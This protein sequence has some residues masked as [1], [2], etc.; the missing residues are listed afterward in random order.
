MKPL[1]AERWARAQQLFHE[2]LALPPADRADHVRG[3]TDEPDVIELVLAMI[4]ADASSA[5]PLD[6]D[7]GA[8]ADGLLAA[9]ESPGRRLGHYVLG[10]VLG[11]GG[12]AVVYRAYR[13][14]LGNTVAIKI[15]RDAWVSPSRRR[16]FLTEQRT[17]AALTHP[18]IA[19]LL[20]ADTLEDG[21]PY[22][23]MEHV[24]GSPITEHCTKLSLPLDDRLRLFRSVC[25][26]VQHAHAHAIVH[27]D[28]K[29]SN[30]LVASDG[31][32]KLLDFGIAKHV[33]ELDTDAPEAATRTGLRPMTP[34]YA[35]PEQIRGDNVGAYTDVYA[36][37]VLLHEILTGA[38]PAASSRATDGTGA[39]LVDDAALRAVAGR[40]AT[41]LTCICRVAMHEEPA[42]RYPTVEALGRDIDRFLRGLPVEARPDSV[43]YRVG[44]FVRRNRGAVAS[45]AA[46]FALLVAGSALHTTRLAAARD[47]AELEAAKAR[48]V[49]DYLVGLFEAAD[50]YEDAAESDVGTLLDRGEARLSGLGA[51]PALQ[52]DLF[53]VLGRVRVARSEFEQAETLLSRALDMQRMYSD[54]LAVA[55]TLVEIGRLHYYTGRYAEAATALA[56]ALAIRSAHL[57]SYDPALAEAL[58]ELGV[59]TSSLGDYAGADTLFG[60]ALAIRRMVHRE[61]HPDLG[62]SLNN[63]AV[64]EFNLGRYDSAARYYEETLTVERALYG[65]DH[66]TVATTLAN[67]GKLHEQ[68][69]N[70]GEAEKLLTQALHIR[71]ARLGADHYETALSLSQLGGLLQ[72]AGDLERA[73]RYLRDALAIR[74]RILG[75]DHP[76]VGTTLNAIGLLLGQRGEHDDAIAA[77]HRV[78]GIYERALG[79]EH[80]FTG[81]ARGNLAEALQARGDL[82]EAE[83][84]YRYSIAILSAVHPPDH[85]ELAWNVGRLGMLLAARNRD[86]EADS[87]LRT[88][89]AALST[90]YGPEHRRTL[91]L[92]ATIERVS[93]RLAQQ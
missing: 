16:R 89:H 82:D 64:N 38:R 13:D 34:A 75:P 4:E 56:E 92:G 55:A 72:Q 79:A 71:Q 24:E 17:L 65:A 49:A 58:D 18:N 88:A 84:Q 63:V 15:L 77:F 29:P 6:S 51:Q 83:R 78:I 61:P 69:G 5:S 43:P 87:L 40:S 7:V 8:A 44:K 90:A 80:R 9:R 22:F 73:E 57:G 74:E 32:V 26:A 37:G 68:V 30:V 35:A 66:P 2:S 39:A 48:E 46:V 21:T 10:D 67:Y 1:D 20:D 52:A 62:V 36:L 19:R 25:D 93:Q 14:D 12:A 23:V 81:V 11:E 59:I 50:P 53:G 91:V 28:I 85:P 76:G 31:R 33:A 47:R 45:A 3:A 70:Y 54:A 86:A 60:R 27:R 42:R 41:D